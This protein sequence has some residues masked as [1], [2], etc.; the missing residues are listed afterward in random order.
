MTLISCAARRV[1]I[2][3]DP[4]TPFPDYPAVHAQVSNACAGVRTLTAELGLS[5]RAGRQR[6]RGRV[7]AGFE[8][9]AS[10][11]LEGVAPFGGP[12]FILAASGATA[13]LLLPRDNR[14]VHDS[15]ADEIL[16]ALTGVR[17]AP[18]D[19]QAILTGCVTVQPRAVAGRLHPNNWASVDLQGGATIFLRRDAGAWR[20]RAA[21]RAGWQIEYP[22]WQ[23]RFPATVRL[24]S[25]SPDADV[26]L[27]ATV[28]QLETNVH[29]EAAAFAVVVPP[30]AIE[31]TLKELRDA[32]PLGER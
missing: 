26:D 1:E 3:T 23:G 20:P 29:L 25:E 22:V 21:R 9:P 7:V 12:T 17:L 5:G 10:M 28:A 24:L 27:T 8:Q 31:L 30:D 13:T 15:R 11:R 32:G 2:P 19:L 14:V 4:G 16:G 18:G 6:I